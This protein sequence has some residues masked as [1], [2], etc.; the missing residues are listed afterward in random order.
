ME[1]EWKEG[2]KYKIIYYHLLL[3]E[4]RRWK[5]KKDK[6]RSKCRERER[7]GKNGHAHTK[8]RKEIGNVSDRRKKWSCKRGGMC[9][10]MCVREINSQ[11]QTEIVRDRE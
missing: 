9:V 3:T 10:Y 8:M 5:R 6:R 1:V 7:G 4:E 11:R 2:I